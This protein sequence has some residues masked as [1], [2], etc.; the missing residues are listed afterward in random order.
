M[1]VDGRGLTLLHDAFGGF[2]WSFSRS[3]VPQPRLAP[4]CCCLC[5]Q[6]ALGLHPHLLECQGESNRASLK[7]TQSALA[8]A[9]I[10]TRGARDHFTLRRNR[11]FS[12]RDATAEQCLRIVPDPQCLMFLA[13]MQN[14]HAGSSLPI[15]VCALLTRK[16][17]EVEQKVSHT[18]RVRG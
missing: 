14:S 5:E 13:L 9:L 18:P 2:I 17:V 12:S 3:S 7:V 1:L 11:K 6:T 15:I 10:S 8:A 16:S 4:V